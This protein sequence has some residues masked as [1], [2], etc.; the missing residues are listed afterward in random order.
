MMMMMTTMM[1]KTRR[2]CIT[3]CDMLYWY[4]NDNDRMNHHITSKNTMEI[5]NIPTQHFLALID[6]PT[7]STFSPLSTF[8]SSSPMS[9]SESAHCSRLLIALRGYLSKEICCVGWGRDMWIGEEGKGTDKGSLLVDEELGWGVC[10]LS[11]ALG[12]EGGRE[13]EDEE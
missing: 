10:V 8:S 9:K 2:I 1:N 7:H 11:F 6:E 12:R 13:R 3:N 5:R 4:D